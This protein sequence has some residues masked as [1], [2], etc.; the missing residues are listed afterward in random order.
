MAPA[1]RPRALPPADRAPTAAEAL[2]TVTENYAAGHRTADKLDGL[3]DWVR[4]Q[5]KVR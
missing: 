1:E 3:Q 5:G 4:K 2:S